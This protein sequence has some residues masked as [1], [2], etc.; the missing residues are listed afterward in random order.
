MARNFV[1]YF[2]GTNNIYC[3]TNTQR[4]NIE[5]FVVLIT[6]QNKY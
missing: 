6:Q 3:V 4:L 5:E 2:G 1:F